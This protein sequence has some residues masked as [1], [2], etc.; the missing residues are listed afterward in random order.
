MTVTATSSAQ[1]L[2]TLEDLYDIIMRGI[3]PELVSDNLDQLDQLYKEETPAE[4]IKRLERYQQAIT[5]CNQ[6]WSQC[7]AHWESA[8]QMAALKAGTTIQSTAA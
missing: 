2:C 4:N 7:M 5:K 1:D 8:L 3:E 6:L